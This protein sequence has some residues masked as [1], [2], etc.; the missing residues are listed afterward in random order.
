MKPA[1]MHAKITTVAKE[2]TNGD[3][4]HANTIGRLLTNQYN[5]EPLLRAATYDHTV[6][7][8]DL[9][10]DLEV[11]AVVADEPQG[12]AAIG[13]VLA[14]GHWVSGRNDRAMIH[15]ERARAADGTNVLTQ[16]VMSAIITGLPTSAWAE[17]MTEHSM[18]QLMGN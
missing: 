13:S 11:I 10:G 4:S 5:R 14:L 7:L 8:H 18:K 17:V 6:D 9:L 12:L 1:T 3:R 2:I 15:A 16:L